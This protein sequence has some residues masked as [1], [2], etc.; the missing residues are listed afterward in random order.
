MRRE[1]NWGLCP[2]GI[3]PVVTD[4]WLKGNFR[5]KIPGNAGRWMVGSE[6]HYSCVNFFRGRFLHNRQSLIRYGLWI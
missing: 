5:G 3:I 6:N 2:G 1:Y 4:L